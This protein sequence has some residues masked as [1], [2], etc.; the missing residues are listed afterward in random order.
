MSVVRIS[1]DG[2]DQIV[3]VDSAD[4]VAGI[5]GSAKRGRYHVDEIS[6]DPLPSGHTSRT[7]GPPMSHAEIA[8]D[9]R[10]Q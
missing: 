6:A 7:W 4:Q 10:A 9:R 1:R 3:D 2:K 8:E 5:V